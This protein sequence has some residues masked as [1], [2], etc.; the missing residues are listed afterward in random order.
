MVF[1]ST[2]CSHGHSFLWKSETPDHTIFP[3]PLAASKTPSPGDGADIAEPLL[4]WR[5]L[6]PTEKKR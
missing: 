5:L 3:F 2:V 4:L 1:F 6:S